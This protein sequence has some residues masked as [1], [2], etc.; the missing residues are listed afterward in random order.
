MFDLER[1][2]TNYANMTWLKW[3]IVA[4]ALVWAV[5]VP[6]VPAQG[7]SLEEVTVAASIDDKTGVQTAM[8]YSVERGETLRDLARLLRFDV[9]LVAAM[10]GMGPEDV[11]KQGQV[12]VFP[13]EADITYVVQPGDTVWELARI[14][15]TGVERIISDNDLADADRLLV[16]QELSIPAPRTAIV[17]AAE[18]KVRS[19]GNEETFK[20][21]SVESGESGREDSGSGEAQE[22]QS[23]LSQLQW[24]TEGTVSSVFGMRDDRMHEGLDIA[25]PEG[26]V[27][28]AALPGRVVFAGERGTYGNAV[29]LR[30]GDRIRTLYG[31]ASRILVEEGEWVEQGEPIAE[32]GNTGHSTGPHLHFEVILH[33]TPLDPEK[34]LP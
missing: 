30:H 15:G 20:V 31:H 22:P 7:M 1:T 4:V 10:N 17:F 8:V 29:I 12:I 24:P 9:E 28:R 6:V 23:R 5:V 19:R 2:F 34:Y 14:Y 16:G 26:V 32:V 25:A 13:A 3:P 11:L 18:K 27:I 33:G 21:M